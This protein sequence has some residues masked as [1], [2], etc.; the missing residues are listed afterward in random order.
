MPRLRNESSEGL[1]DRLLLSNTNLW[2][3]YMVHIVIIGTVVATVMII[4]LCRISKK[5]VP[6]P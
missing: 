3:G 6:L 2:R 4:S 1:R 5:K